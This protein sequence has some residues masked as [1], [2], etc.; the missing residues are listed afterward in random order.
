MI[1]A[2]SGAAHGSDV[3][4]ADVGATRYPGDDIGHSGSLTLQQSGV[5]GGVLLGA[6]STDVPAGSL[7]AGDLDGYFIQSKRVTISA[8]LSYGDAEAGSRTIPLYKARLA[9]DLQINSSWSI[10]AADQ[11]ID[12]DLVHGQT[13][14]FSS[15]YRVAPSWG[16]KCAGGFSPGG[17]IAGRYGEIALHWY[18]PQYVFGGIV[19]GRTGYDLATLGEVDEV[20]QLRQV[21]AGTSIPFRRMTLNIAA[22]IL[23]LNGLPRQTLHIGVSWPIKS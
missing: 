3:V 17:T 1:M 10:R 14:T 19:I 5:D 4:I 2:L 12:F 13:L 7:I 20:Q 22:D 9:A 21:Y 6:S 11:Y 16:V 15:E 23:T 18:G 8:G